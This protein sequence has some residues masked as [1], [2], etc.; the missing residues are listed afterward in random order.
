MKFGTT[1][2]RVTYVMKCIVRTLLA[3]VLVLSSSPLVPRQAAADDVSLE[4]EDLTAAFNATGLVIDPP[5]RNYGAGVHAA[6][7]GL[8]EGVAATLVS[9]S[10]RKKSSR[11]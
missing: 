6:V 4:V 8:P 7:A 3:I 5:K 9:V 2:C 10:I 1:S 11:L